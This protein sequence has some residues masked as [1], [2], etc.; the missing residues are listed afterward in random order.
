MIRRQ[1]PE[2]FSEQQRHRL[3]RLPRFGVEVALGRAVRETQG[4]HGR[5][6]FGEAIS[7]DTESCSNRRKRP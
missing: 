4:R 7:H 3:H 2:A 1:A 5:W 6:G